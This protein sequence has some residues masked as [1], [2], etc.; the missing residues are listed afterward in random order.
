MQQRDSTGISID[1]EVIKHVPSL[2]K[3]AQEIMQL[4]SSPA[5]S[6]SCR[7]I[8]SAFDSWEST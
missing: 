1:E 7:L 2:S 5:L 8:I 3:N 6:R 4:L